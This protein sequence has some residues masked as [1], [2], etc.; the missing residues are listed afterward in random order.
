MRPPGAVA[1]VAVQAGRPARRALRRR[2][3]ARRA[4]RRPSHRARH[5]NEGRDARRR[6]RTSRTRFARRWASEARRSPSALGN[7]RTRNRKAPRM[8]DARY[9]MR[10]HTGGSLTAELDRRDGSPRRMGRQAP[11]PRWTDL[12]RP[13][14]PHRNRPVHLR[15]GG[16]R[17]GVRDRRAGAPRVGRAARGRRAPASGGHRE[18]EH[19][20]R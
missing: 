8:L 7:A 9:S 14:G 11:R 4:R 17:R 1:Q 2:R 19:G 3:R 16:V 13:A 12:R 18:P 20:D 6:R 15:S 5:G 10:S